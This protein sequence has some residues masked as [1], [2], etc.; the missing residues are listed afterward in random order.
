MGFLVADNKWDTPGPFLRWMVCW[1][2]EFRFTESFKFADDAGK[3]YQ[4]VLA[5]LHVK[6]SPML[7]FGTSYQFSWRQLVYSVNFFD[8]VVPAY[9][10][11]HLKESEGFIVFALH[12]QAPKDYAWWLSWI[13]RGSALNQNLLKPG[14]YHGKV[15]P[16]PA[17]S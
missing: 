4:A 8:K 5:M 7:N 15:R 13:N 17:D 12:R 1:G 2:K 10:F 16:S 3:R 11:A 14:E 9:D 6:V